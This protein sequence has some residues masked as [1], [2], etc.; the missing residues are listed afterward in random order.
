MKNA[1][2]AHCSLTGLKLCV[3]SN[4]FTV[5]RKIVYGNPIKICGMHFFSSDHHLKQVFEPEKHAWLQRSERVRLLWASMMLPYGFQVSEKI[6]PRESEQCALL[7]VYYFLRTFS[8]QSVLQALV[9]FQNSEFADLLKGQS[10]CILS[11]PG[12]LRGW[13]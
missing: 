6:A 10:G 8:S 13:P 2:V 1:V 3:D 11:S 5:V 4:M 12:K 9:I 7:R